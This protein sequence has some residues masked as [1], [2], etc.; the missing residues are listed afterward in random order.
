MFDSVKHPY[1]KP[2]QNIIHGPGLLNFILMACHAQK[3]AI[4]KTIANVSVFILR[5]L[6]VVVDAT[7]R[8]TN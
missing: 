7:H 5:M 3:I 4:L 8:Y 6:L 2:L 1:F